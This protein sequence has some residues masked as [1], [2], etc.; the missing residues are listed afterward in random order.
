MCQK[1]DGCSGVDKYLHDEP[2]EICRD[3]V[4][5]FQAR[6]FRRKV[7]LTGEKFEISF[8]EASPY[9]SD[10]H[11]YQAG[12]TEDRGLINLD[13]DDER[14]TTSFRMQQMTKDSINNHDW[15]LTGTCEVIE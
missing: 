3:D 5:V 2:T 10:F 15:V 7:S 6:T 4:Q 9:F 1:A 14:P 12:A 13:F 8:K 11:W